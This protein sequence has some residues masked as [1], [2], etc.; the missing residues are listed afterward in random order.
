MLS[1]L[2]CGAA[3]VRPS[4]PPYVVYSGTLRISLIPFL[5][6]A[7]YA[8]DVCSHSDSVSP[9]YPHAASFW[10]RA[11]LFSQCSD[12]EAALVLVRWTFSEE[13][14]HA[15]FFSPRLI[16]NTMWDARSARGVP[17]VLSS[18]VAA[19]LEGDPGSLFISYSFRNKR[20]L[21]AKG[22]LSRQGETD[23]FCVLVLTPHEHWR[24]QNEWIVGTVRTDWCWIN[25]ASQIRCSVT[26]LKLFFIYNIQ[27]CRASRDTVSIHVVTFS[28]L[29]THVYE[30]CWIWW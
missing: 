21:H 2:W 8:H 11:G 12:S 3:R 16:F 19:W 14:I 10:M 1:P 18:V 17:G 25:K 24:K 13:G 22:G 7:F 29:P 20:S 26:G 30:C 4:A 27:D 6:L 23:Y 9:S 15:F 5:P 28:F